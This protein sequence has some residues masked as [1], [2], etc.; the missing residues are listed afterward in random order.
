M[1]IRYE[2]NKMYEIKPIFD[3]SSIQVDLPTCMY[4]M[5]NISEFNANDTKSSSPSS[6]AQLTNGF[7]GAVSQLSTKS[8]PDVKQQIEKFLK[9]FLF[10]PSNSNRPIYFSSNFIFFNFFQNF[11][12][13]STLFSQNKQKSV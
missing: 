1:V 10:I 7:N 11:N 12:S 9:V 8:L 13:I 4:K 3:R 5:K 2:G 6:N